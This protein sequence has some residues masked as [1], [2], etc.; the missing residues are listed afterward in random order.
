MAYGESLVWISSATPVTARRH[1]R[2]GRLTIRH[3]R[4]PR[5]L[6]FPL[7]QPKM[8][9][10]DRF[11]Q[12]WSNT[13]R[14]G[15]KNSGSLR[16]SALIGK[17]HYRPTLTVIR[18][19]S[20]RDTPSSTSPKEHRAQRRKRKISTYQQRAKDGTLRNSGCESLRCQEEPIF[21][22]LISS[23]VLVPAVPER[24]FLFRAPVV[25]PQIST[26]CKVTGA[27]A[28]A[29]SFLVS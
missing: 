21:S 17:H 27:L 14:I 16:R 13:S 1:W 2:H 10:S 11:W 26:R 8:S 23:I 5:C 25:A 12:S 7:Y 4:H 29:C 6:T 19:M 22:D 15:R 18:I 28:S 24:Q 9:L 3:H 20:H